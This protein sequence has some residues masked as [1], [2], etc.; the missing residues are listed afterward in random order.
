M[1]FFIDFNYLNDATFGKSINDFL[2]KNGFKI[3]K[4]VF[5]DVEDIRTRVLAH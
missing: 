5:I 4:N 3:I 1:K 2:N